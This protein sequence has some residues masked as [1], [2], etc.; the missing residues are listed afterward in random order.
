MYLHNA[1]AESPRAAENTRVQDI[2]TLIHSPSRVVDSNFGLLQLDLG[3][4]RSE[5]LECLD[6]SKRR[7]KIYLEIKLFSSRVESA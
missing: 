1:S 4:A 2:K 3:K 7:S 6:N 5:I